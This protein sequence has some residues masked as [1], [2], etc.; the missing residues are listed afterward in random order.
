[1]YSRAAM[2]A[3]SLFV[4]D[5]PQLVRQSVQGD[6]FL[7]EID[8]FVQH[9]VVSDNVARIAGHEQTPE[10]R[11]KRGQVTKKPKP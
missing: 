10:S 7:N 5:L 3:A 11:V 4:Q 6:R 2:M 1:M 8:P 9:A